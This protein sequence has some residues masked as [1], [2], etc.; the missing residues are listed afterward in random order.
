MKVFLDDAV[1][2]QELIKAQQNG[3]LANL[4]K[5]AYALR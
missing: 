2:E 4:N 1:R 5:T 3:Q